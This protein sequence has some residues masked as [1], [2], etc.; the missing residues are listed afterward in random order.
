MPVMPCRLHVSQAPHDRSQHKPFE[1]TPLAHW[2]WSEHITPKPFKQVPLRSHCLGAG[3]VSPS[4]SSITGS[5]VPP[6]VAHD[7]QVPQLA[8]LQH[9][10]STQ[11]PDAHSELPAHAA[12]NGRFARMDAA[13]MPAS[14]ALVPAAPAPPTPALGA[15][16][17]DPAVEPAAA[18]LSPPSAADVTDA[19]SAVAVAPPL[20]AATLVPASA[21]LDTELAVGALSVEVVSAGLDAERSS[22]SRRGFASG[23]AIELH[24]AVSATLSHVSPTPRT[25][26][27]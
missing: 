27:R 21:A 4:D 20:P 25:G 26:A 2:R 23:T 8:V 18:S 10:P 16:A 15:P 9:V 1:H 7:S 22:P 12:A 17:G 24:A 13:S 3:H 14:L 19:A 11:E 6:D 5:Q